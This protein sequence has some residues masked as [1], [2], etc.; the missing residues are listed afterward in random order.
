MVVKRGEIK[1]QQ[2]KVQNYASVE[3]NFSEEQM[4][5]ILSKF[6]KESRYRR[7]QGKLA[8]IIRILPHQLL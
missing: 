2:N 7:Y 4:Q 6:D 8:L 3:T 1:L 5:E